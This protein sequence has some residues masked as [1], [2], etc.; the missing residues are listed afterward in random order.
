MSNINN[1]NCPPI[2]ISS[3]IF[4]K[5]GS[6]PIK[7]SSLPGNDVPL[8]CTLQNLFDQGIID[9]SSS[10]GLDVGDTDCINLTLTGAGSV[11][12][13]WIIS[14]DPIISPDVNNTLECRANGLFTQP[15]KL[16]S[17]FTTIDPDQCIG[18]GAGCRS[19]CFQFLGISGCP[20]NTNIANFSWRFINTAGT[21]DVTEDGGTA[22]SFCH[23]FP[24]DGQYS[25]ILTTTLGNGA[26]T[27][28][29]INIC[30]DCSCNDT[31]TMNS[32]TADYTATA[33]D[34]VIIADVVGN[35]ITV[36]LPD[37]STYFEADGNCSEKLTIKVID[38]DAETTG[39]S[40]TFTITS[41]SP[42]DG[43][44]TINFLNENQSITV[45]SDGT[46]YYTL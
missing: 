11:G 16:G 15:A 23:D 27:V 34:N 35:A 36:T 21:Y 33:T 40:N 46:N 45:V 9:V 14:A 38:S 44:T 8:I 37:A 25:V 17:I 39:L 26:Q 41:V 5:K 32:I 2:C 7:N 1:L 18:G 20:A 3:E 24:A 30:I 19:R 28:D 4:L 29:L 6:P 12:D 31:V 42:I 22:T 13:P 10:A 43:Q